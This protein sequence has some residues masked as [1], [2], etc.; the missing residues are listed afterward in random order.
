MNF[1]KST[2]DPEI[3]Q[4]IRTQHRQVKTA[5]PCPNPRVSDTFI[6]GAAQTDLACGQLNQKSSVARCCL[7]P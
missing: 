1:K 2:R 5:D 4:R 3:S 7:G 6:L